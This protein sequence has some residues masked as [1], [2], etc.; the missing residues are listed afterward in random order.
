MRQ[1]HWK[2]WL[3][4]MLPALLS[5]TAAAQQSSLTLRQA[6][7]RALGENP[8]TAMASDDVSAARAG[9]LL[10]H[11]ALWPRL[12][13]MEDI[14][15]GNDPVY[16]FGTKLR[17][18]RFSQTDFALNALN[19]PT[20]LGNF[21]TRLSGQWMLF[22]GFSTQQQIRAAQLGVG[23]ATSASKSVNQAVVLQ[24]VQAYQAVLYAQRQAEL[25]AHEQ[26]TAEALLQDAQTRV[27]AGLAVDSDLLGAQVNLSARQQEWIAAQ[28]GVQSAWAG[29]QAAMGSSSLAE[30]ALQPLQARRYPAGDLAEDIAAAL[31]ARPDLKALAQQSAAAGHAVKA[32]WGDFFPTL[33][34]YGNLET[35]R[36][37]FA[38]AGGTN[39]VAGAQLS[40]NVL[41]LAT[42]AHLQQARAAQQRA[43]AQQRA[44]ELAIRLGVSHAFTA[45]QT[46]EQTVATTRAAMDQAT[47]SLRILR[48]R[49]AA[50]L[51][52]MTDLLRAED[53]LRRSE[54][55]YWRAAYGNTVAYAELLFATGHLTPDSAENLQ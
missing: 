36:P 31:K 53:A 7:D 4:G 6:I 33:S 23:S 49:Y 44:Q 50:G 25:A 8:Q 34:A 45:H 11:S 35:D 16:V 46:A 39:W 55:N 13:A 27:H 26:K 17:Q 10:T 9:A 38:G 52:T 48:N 37:T 40:L 30:P 29:L 20:P 2:R 12:T 19:R 54:A 5:L 43:E 18:Q 51:A 28:G 42:R 32:A 47:E 24:V 15:R 22:N 41:P 1:S 14:S 3:A 21:A